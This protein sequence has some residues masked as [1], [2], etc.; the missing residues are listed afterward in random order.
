MTR[1]MDVSKVAGQA[2]SDGRIN[3]PV[4]EDDNSNRREV[5]VNSSSLQRI[6]VQLDDSEKTTWVQMGRRT[7]MA[8]QSSSWIHSDD[9]GRT[10]AVGLR[11][12]MSAI[13]G[14]DVMIPRRVIN[15]RMIN[16]AVRAGAQIHS[17]RISDSDP[18]ASIYIAEA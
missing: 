9:Q 13:T 1:T 8:S 17:A 7:S 12:V 15:W 2:G 10:E 5:A 16:L 18:W 11:K 14:D 6:A 4:A 3:M